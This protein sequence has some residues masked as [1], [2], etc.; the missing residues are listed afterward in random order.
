LVKKINIKVITISL[1]AVLLL[2]SFSLLFINIFNTF[3][4][5]E[6]E[7]PKAAT[8]L[9]IYTYL[10]WENFVASVA[11]GNN[12]EGMVVN[13]WNDV[14][15]QGKSLELGWYSTGGVELNRRFF[16]GT[17]DGHGHTFYNIVNTF[18]PKIFSDYNLE[19]ERN[20][21][22]IF[23][24]NE[25]TIKNLKIKDYKCIIENGFNSAV[26]VGVIAGYNS[27][28][29]S[30]CIVEN[31][32]FHSKR[33]AEFAKV[34]SLV[35]NNQGT[36]TRC[37][38]TGSYKLR[39]ENF[40]TGMYATYFSGKGEAGNSIFLASVD[41]PGGYKTIYTPQEC[42]SGLDSGK[43]N[44]GNVSDARKAFI[45]N[46]DI[47]KADVKYRT[48][49]VDVATS[50]YC[51][52]GYYSGSPVP[53]GAI[54][55]QSVE[56]SSGTLTISIDGEVIN[57][58]VYLRIPDGLETN[59]FN[60]DKKHYTATFDFYNRKIVAAEAT[61]CYAFNYWSY[62]PGYSGNYGIP[63]YSAIIKNK[64]ITIKFNSNANATNT[65]NTNGYTVN[66][67]TK[68]I[69]EKTIN[70]ITFT[71]TTIDKKLITITYTANPTHYIEKVYV[72]GVNRAFS[73]GKFIIHSH[74]DSSVATIG[75]GCLI[76]KYNVGFG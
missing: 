72:D 34:G 63:R 75:I 11:D 71:F 12:Y 24:S 35:G 70:K 47:S 55:W 61:D 1:L 14:N 15:C 7:S 28:T 26:H 68:I 64:A 58:D 41:E 5:N 48:G 49:G 3:K 27:G 45:G 42:S 20:S 57:D 25:G 22:G 30:D 18:D 65:S 59:V 62:E 33:I 17:F 67:G 40:S 66:C 2:S 52:D 51:I 23:V 13:L 74:G 39:R 8:V 56:I 69:V 31:V 16:K 4:S 53:R 43:T 9:D 50:W 44:Y 29:I 21:Y 76:K 36:L 10:G 38:V 19:F 73:D 6:H 54:L 60:S 32:E 46:S 37:L